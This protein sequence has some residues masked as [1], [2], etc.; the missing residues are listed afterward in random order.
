[1]VISPVYLYAER[2][3]ALLHRT[4]SGKNDTG[5]HGTENGA[6]NAPGYN[7]KAPE[8]HVRDAIHAHVVVI[9]N[10]LHD[11]EPLRRVPLLS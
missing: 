1:M 11:S 2:P 8:H 4:V 3:E 5:R 9:G 7:P 10:A 6:S